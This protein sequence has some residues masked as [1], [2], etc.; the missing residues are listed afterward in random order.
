M[1][2]RSICFAFTLLGVPAAVAQTS[3][4]K[5]QVAAAPKAEVSEKTLKTLKQ[6]AW[7][8]LPTKIVMSDQRTVVIDKADPSK[9]IIPDPEA[10]D[11]IKLAHLTARAH[12][13]NMQELVIAN[14]DAI[15]KREKAKNK[16][17]ESQLFYIN[18]LHLYT[19]Q[20]LV[21]KVGE[22]DADKP[23]PQYQTNP[24]VPIPEGEKF[25]ACN[26]KEK[27]EIQK[28]VEANFFSKS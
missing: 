22:L 20:L 23:K 11:V 5:G 16:W 21:G 19:V 28:S 6:L 2:L 3:V 7:Q 27:D 8:S 13:C 10:R 17:S 14:R 1:S 12:K 9:I 18:A 26:Q 4:P 24:N 15:L 25:A